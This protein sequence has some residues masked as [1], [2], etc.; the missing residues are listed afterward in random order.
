LSPPDFV[1]IGADKTK[2]LAAAFAYRGTRPRFVN[3]S[4]VF[5]AS[6]F[7]QLF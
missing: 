2:V 3:T 6:L 4:G 5:A 7:K 1:F